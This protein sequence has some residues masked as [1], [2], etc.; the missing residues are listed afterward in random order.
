VARSRAIAAAVHSLVPALA[1][2]PA[3]RSASAASTSARASGQ[4]ALDI[5]AVR[6]AEGEVLDAG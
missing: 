2:L 3:A 5:H 1:R 4:P 6:T